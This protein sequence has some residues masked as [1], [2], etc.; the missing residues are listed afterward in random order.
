MSAYFAFMFDPRNHVIDRVDLTSATMD[1]AVEAASDL[2]RADAPRCET[3]EV[4]HGVRMVRRLERSA[5]VPGASARMQ[6]N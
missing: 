4:W 3:V 1:E 6:M 2:L 5:L